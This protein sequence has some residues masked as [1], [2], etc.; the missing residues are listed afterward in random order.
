[1]HHRISDEHYHM[2]QQYNRYKRTVYD[3]NK[4]HYLFP[5]FLSFPYSYPLPLCIT[6]FT[7]FLLNRLGS[8]F[9]L[10]PNPVSAYHD[11][12]MIPLFFKPLNLVSS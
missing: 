5:R 9:C 3:T 4:T 8:W 7:E 12:I 1:M 6:R 10:G 2:I 11:Y